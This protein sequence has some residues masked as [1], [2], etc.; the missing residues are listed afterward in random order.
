M[1]NNFNN[2][3]CMEKKKLSLN[4]ETI[5]SLDSPKMSNV[6]GGAD[7]WGVCRATYRCD[8]NTGGCSDG[9]GTMLWCTDGHCTVDCPTGME[10][11]YTSG[12]N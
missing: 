9:C 1:S 3:K 7:A 8:K 11:E 2:F 10:K 6:L 4:K 12:E 5:S